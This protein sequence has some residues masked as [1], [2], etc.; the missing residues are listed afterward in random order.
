[1]NAA[2]CIIGRMRMFLK[3]IRAI[4]KPK[5]RVY[6]ALA[7]CRVLTEAGNDAAKWVVY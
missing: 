3:Q 1:M 7:R 2:L 6:R 4:S 5:T